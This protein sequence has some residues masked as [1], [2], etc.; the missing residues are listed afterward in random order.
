M[1]VLMT[2][3][4]VGGVWT[5]V[6][7]LMR[8]LQG[9]V[10]FA[11]ATMGAPLTQ[12]QH[13][14]AA[15]LSNLT[16][17][18]SSYQLEWMDSPWRDVKQAGDWLLQLERDFAPDVIHLNG[19][20]HGSLAWQAPS[21]IVG[22]SCV[23]SWWQAVKGECAPSI[24][25]YYRERVRDGLQSAS[26]VV[27]PTQAMLSALEQH[28]GPLPHSVVIPNGRSA[29]RFHVGA[30]ESF[31][32]AAGRLWD[33]GKN[34]LTL[35][36]AAP[37]IPWQVV[38]AGDSTHPDGRQVHFKNMHALGSLS[39]SK[40]ANWMSR[41]PILVLPARY[42]PFGLTP[43]EAA[44]SGC[45]LV[46]GDIPSLRDVWGDAAVFVS[47]DDDR[48]LARAINHLITSP[49]ARQIMAT[50]ALSRAREYPP[51][52]FARNYLQL[53]QQLIVNHRSIA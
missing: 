52:S 37:H 33:E 26:L 24:Y 11:L 5:Y 28:Y 53:Y 25:D 49:A 35:A 50:R 18:E 43:L 38:I 27:A 32:L 16:L 51:E 3:D 36:K 4:T 48:A 47:P 10:D 19:Y 41:A 20:V 44:L 45:A 23:L 22:H 46:L 30:K 2:A 1:R 21:L 9:Q 34:I 17:C 14:E 8:A 15:I 12:D 7:E 39:P 40:L 29:D 42:E 31:V 13:E 6:L